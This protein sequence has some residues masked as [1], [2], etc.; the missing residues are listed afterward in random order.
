MAACCALGA[1]ACSNPDDTAVGGR[2]PYTPSAL[3]PLTSAPLGDELTLVPSHAEANPPDARNP[4]DPALRAAQLAEGFGA[5]TTAAGESYTTL[6]PPGATPPAPGPAPKLLARFGHLADFQLADDESPSRLALFDTPGVTNAAFRP[7]EGH[8]CRILNAL[9]RTVNKIHEAQPLDFVLLGGDNADNAE[10]AELAWVMAILGGSQRV[11]CDSGADDDPLAGA[12]NDP[13]DPFIA[14]GLGMRWYWVTGNHDVLKQ[15]NIPVSDLLSAEATGDTAPGGTRD[16]SRAGG[17]LFKNPVVIDPARAMLERPEL[18]ARIAADGDGHGIG[19]AQVT[20]GK[21]YYTFDIANTPLRFVILDSAAESGGSEGIVRQGDL[22][23]FLKP[24]LDQA[25]ADGKWVVLASHHAVA[26]LGNGVGLGG[27]EQPDAVLPAAYTSFIGTYP[28]VLFSMVGHSHRHQV[29]FIEPATGHAWWE[30]LTSALADFPNQ[31][32]VVEIWDEDNGWVR[33]RATT[34]DY[35][36]EGD[37]VAQEGRA[38]GILDYATGW[39]S[40]GRGTLADRNVD[41][42]IAAPP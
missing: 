27:S 5:F 41:L 36:T 4:S 10:G 21:A 15:G 11:E 24:A 23:S 18:M 38:L 8:E 13:K 34:L 12:D 14:D 9:V 40:D 17:P 1:A 6:A 16:W 32:R 30:V 22:D 28:N 19:S 39:A 25:L 3:P 35:A 33:L 2:S 26:S 7:Q 37:P 42:W 29:R 31:A 20:S